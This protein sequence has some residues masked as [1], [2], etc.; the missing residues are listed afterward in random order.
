[1]LNGGKVNGILC[2]TVDSANGMTPRSPLFSFGLNITTPPLGPPGTVSHVLF[3]AD[4]AKLR[5]TS[6]GIAGTGNTPNIPGFMA[7]W[8]VAPD[9][10]LSSEFTKTAP[11]NGDGLLPFGM[12]NVPGLPDSIIVTDPA[13]GM[14]LYDF[15]GSDPTFSPLTI[16]GQI[17]T[18]WA[19]FASTSNSFFLS[20]DSAFKI[21]EVNVGSSNDPKLVNTYNLE[22]NSSP[23]DIVIASVFGTE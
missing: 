19:E 3:S 8:D 7:T 15:S 23:T 11:P 5:A 16:A 18:C 10:T 4:G 20:D 1:M 17:A 9:G 12:S 14:A 6:K 13:L 2:Y 22:N 21:Y